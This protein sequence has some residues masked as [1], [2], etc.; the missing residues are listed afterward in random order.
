L[1]REYLDDYKQKELSEY[2]RSVTRRI[3]KGTFSF[4]KDKYPPEDRFAGLKRPIALTTLETARITNVWAQI[5]FCGSLILPLP[6]WPEEEYEKNLFKLSEASEIIDFIKETGKIQLVIHADPLFYEGLDYLDPFFEELNPPWYLVAP[7]SL[8]GN[9]KEIHEAL[10]SFY[11]LADVKF[12]KWLRRLDLFTPN[13][14]AQCLVDCANDY[15]VLRRGGY[16]PL[17]EKIE[18]LLI[19]NPEEALSLFILS[20]DFITGPISDLL[21]DTQSFALEDVKKVKSLPPVYQPRKI[22]FPYEIGKFLIRKLTYAP[23]GLDACRELMYHYDAY[24]LQKTQESLNEAILTNRPDILEKN[25]KEVSEILDNIW[26]DKA[27]PRKI[28]GLKIGIPVL[29]AAI[30]SV[31]AGPIGAAGGFLA[32]L[33]YDV[34]GK[35]LDLET[36]GLSERLA[37]L[38]TKSYQA[39]IYDFKRKYKSDITHL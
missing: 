7:I 38:K 14:S 32:G 37:K 11:T 23:E 10:D 16:I 36:E 33:G 9:E 35:F 18:N 6:P 34:A 17:L 12:T 19:D 28:E 22:R 3:T 29:M 15:V 31:A 4:G 13:I 21:C 1:D 20:G 39:N 8:W 5:P 25:A 27:I 30:G 2:E 26:N 24:D